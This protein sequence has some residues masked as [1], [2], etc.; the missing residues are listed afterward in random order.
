MK[1]IK[2]TLTLITL[3]LIACVVV[4]FLESCQKD[5]ARITLTK[6]PTAYLKSFTASLPSVINKDIRFKAD[7]MTNRRAGSTASSDMI[8]IGVNFPEN[9]SQVYT[10]QCDNINTLEDMA[11]IAHESGA[12][13]DPQPVG[14]DGYMIAIS[15]NALTGS[16]EDMINDAKNFLY[17]KG[18][19]EED[20]QE[21]LEENDADETTLIPFVLALSVVEA[22]Q[23]EEENDQLSLSSLIPCTKVSA[24]GVT[25]DEVLNCAIQAVGADLIMQLGKSEVKT[26]SVKVVKRLFKTVLPKMVG[27]A[28]VA[29]MIIDFTMCIS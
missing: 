1:R 9:T 28:G 2:L 12:E 23:S 13:F 14:T 20:I 6:E 7:D 16:L 24:A 29:I 27:A 18:F 22:Q 11:R 21:M 19:T 10:D 4:A 25:Q 26:W 3:P 5:T 17:G 8:E 15:K